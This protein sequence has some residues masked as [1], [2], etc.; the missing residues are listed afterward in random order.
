MVKYNT[1]PF[2]KLKLI[3]YITIQYI[4]LFKALK[5]IILLQNTQR[6]PKKGSLRGEPYETN[7][8]KENP[9]FSALAQFTGR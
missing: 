4:T 5:V 2:P 7:S 3:Q 6:I 1:N 8:L 9:K